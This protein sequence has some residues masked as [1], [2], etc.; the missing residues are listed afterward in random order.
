MTQVTADGYSLT[1]DPDLLYTFK[2]IIENDMPFIGDSFKGASRNIE[3]LLA[4]ME[5]VLGND[6]AFITSNY[7]IANGYIEQRMKPLKP[8]HDFRGNEK[9]LVE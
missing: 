3:K 8:G 4:I 5:Y 6:L 1:I 2:K 7:L 9:E